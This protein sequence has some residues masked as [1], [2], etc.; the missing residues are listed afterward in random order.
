MAEAK[1]ESAT[2]LAKT[3]AETAE[4]REVTITVYS[5]PIH[6][7][8]TPAPIT[9]GSA[10]PAGPLEQGKQVEIPVRI[11][12]LY[13][14]DDAVELTLA[15]PNDAGGL[16]AAKVIIPKDRDEGRLVVEATGDAPPG[17]RNPVLQAALK[18]NHQD[19]K[20]EQIIALK[21]IATQKSTSH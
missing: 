9:V 15:F 6:L 7:K 11:N 10:Q 14:Y 20:V 13:N 5:A 18:L 19:L 21:V 2:K 16:T 3:T 4:P 8:V 1:K 17:E 12:R